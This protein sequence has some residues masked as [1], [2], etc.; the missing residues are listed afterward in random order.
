MIKIYSKTKFAIINADFIKES[1]I[2][3]LVSIFLNDQIW[4]IEHIMHNDFRL[5]SRLKTKV[6]NIPV[7][8]EFYVMNHATANMIE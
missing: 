3:T 1:N 2:Y 6:Q 7:R 8:L 4:L 5:S